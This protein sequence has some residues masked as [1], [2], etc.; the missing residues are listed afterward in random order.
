MSLDIWEYLK[1]NAFPWILNAEQM[2]VNKDICSKADLYV[3]IGERNK[4][5]VVGSRFLDCVTVFTYSPNSTELWEI[6]T[7][8]LQ[9]GE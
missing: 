9:A 6:N 7:K 5:L 2:H 3:Y 4:D 1:W 8:F